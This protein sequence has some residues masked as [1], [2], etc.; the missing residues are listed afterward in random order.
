MNEPAG[1]IAT[2]IIGSQ[3]VTAGWRVKSVI[4]VDVIGRVWNRREPGPVVFVEVRGDEFLER[5]V[6]ELPLPPRDPGSY[7]VVTKYRR[8]DFAAIFH[9][10]RFVVGDKVRKD[11]DPEQHKHDD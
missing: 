4:Q 9:D 7:C 2:D 1:H 3:I 5:Y 10:Q 11:S 6:L 8:I